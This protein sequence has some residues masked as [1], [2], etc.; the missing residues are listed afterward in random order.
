[1]RALQCAKHIMEAAMQSASQY[2]SNRD[3]LR[4]ARIEEEKA[5]EREATRRKK[6]H[7]AEV[8]RKTAEAER[9]VAKEEKKRKQ[10]EQKDIAEKERGD[11][12]GECGE[13]SSKRRRA[14]K[15]HD[16]LGEDDFPVVVNKF[17]GHDI[18]VVDSLDKFLES[19][20]FGA[21]VIWRARR[22]PF[23]RVLES[24]DDFSSKEATQGTSL[25][26]GDMRKF[27]DDFAQAVESDPATVKKTEPASS[28]SQQ[29]VQALALEGA[30]QNL[31]G[32][33]L[34]ETSPS[35]NEVEDGCLVIDRTLMNRKLNALVEDVKCD[36]NSDAGLIHKA[37]QELMLYAKLQL[38]AFRKGSQFNGVMSG[39]YPH[40]MYQVDGTRAVTL[41]AIHDVPWPVMVQTHYPGIEDGRLIDRT[42]TTYIWMI[43]YSDSHRSVQ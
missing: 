36:P 24:Q 6:E 2:K 29:Y 32:K 42:R 23:K 35:L 41:I 19:V 9:L 43:L 3:A 26:H 1:M 16:E 13:R 10:Q 30:A 28:D 4:K 34:E 12:T 14:P 8:K 20:L 27:A 17:S 21:P 40:L 38:L 39:L 31:L 37:S 11:T 15:G 22:P 5:A 18:K 7:E 33:W 25:L